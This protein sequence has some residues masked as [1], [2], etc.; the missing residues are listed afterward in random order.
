LCVWFP[1]WPLRR[2]DAPSDE[3]CQVVGADGVVVAANPFAVAAGV[4]VGMPRR[5]SETLCPTIVTLAADPGAEAA[6]F[7]AVA[8][9]VETVAPGVEVV[10]PGLLFLNVSGAVRYYGGEQLLV[11]G[12]ARAI[13]EVAPGARLGL[14]DGPFAARMAAVEGETIVDDTD[15]FVAHL[16]VT[17][18]GMPEIVDT[19]RWLGI[20]TVEDL[21]ALP[22][23]AVASRFGRAGLEAYRLACGEDR[24]VLPRLVPQDVVVEECFDPPLQ[25]LEQAAFAAKSLAYRL[26]KAAGSGVP[27]LLVVEAASASGEVRSRTWRSADPF[28]EGEIAERVRWQLRAWVEGGGIPGGMARLRLVPGDRSDAGRQLCFGE[29]AAS[30]AET[31]RALARAQVLVGPDAVLQAMPQG[32]REPGERVRWCRW[33][34]P[35]PQ[36]VHDPK[37]PWPGRLPG[38]APALLP[39]PRRVEVEWDDG[40]PVRL[41]LGSRW[42]EVCSWAGPWRRTGRWWD[43]E[44]H[45]DRYQIVTSAGAFLCEIRDGDCYLV[46]IY[47]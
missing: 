44:R 27:H 35:A 7:E 40:F 25:D 38:P 1:S 21:A 2:A 8:R 5:R 10:E 37:A 11:A 32:G 22:R 6:S 12:V 20:T 28:S 24:E 42:E 46:G 15:G 16:D 17:A 23:E 34:E 45:A 31:R 30:E 43:G 41:R 47:D 3:P 9:A 13:E 26:L 29:D 14:A 19:F 39:P 36:P 33:G 18:L 4:R